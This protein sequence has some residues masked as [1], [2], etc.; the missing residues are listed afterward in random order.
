MI[1]WIDSGARAR[2][3][4][5]WRLAG[6]AGAVL[7]GLAALGGGS[8]PPLPA[9]AALTPMAKAPP[10]AIS[11]RQPGTSP[12]DGLPRDTHNRAAEEP[13]DFQ[14][15]LLAM[16]QGSMG[17]AALWQL[18]Q[19]GTASADP[20]RRALAYRALRLCAAASPP[21]NAY[22]APLVERPAWL[23]DAAVAQADQAR[24]EMLKR[25]APFAAIRPDERLRLE[26]ELGSLLDP[27]GRSNADP[28]AANPERTLTA[29]RTHLRDTFTRY[30][31]AGLVWAGAD[32]VHYTEQMAARAA[33][34]AAQRGSP[35]TRLSP[36]V[37][38]LALCEL[39]AGCE[40]DSNAALSLCY[41]TGNCSGSLRERLLADY[42]TPEERDRAVTQA[43]QLAAALRSGNL[44][45]Y[46]L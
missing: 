28:T 3:R 45:R 37:P 46:G 1:L 21:Y 14:T 25:C 36:G 26:R 39:D 23:S 12:L 43:R 11:L 5:A 15:Q 10:Q 35:V 9:P 16:V 18:F 40:A 30:G 29:E 42:A 17:G 31:A 33:T 7:L 22:P 44:L 8:V 32:L 38:A 34:G 13:R 6:L 2:R 41:A 24:G 27:P 4:Q 20:Q 19:D